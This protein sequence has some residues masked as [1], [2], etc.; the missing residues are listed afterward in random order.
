MRGK[1]IKKLKDYARTTLKKEWKCNIN[2]YYKDLKKHYKLTGKI[3]F[4]AVD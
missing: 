2:E 3:E 1:M 4:P